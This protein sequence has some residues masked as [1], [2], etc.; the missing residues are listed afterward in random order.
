MP[1]TQEPTSFYLRNR[2]G[3]CFYVSTLDEAL[4]LFVA[5]NGYRLTL[6]GKDTEI[7][8]RRDDFVASEMGQV[9]NATV[10][11]RIKEVEEEQAVLPSNV[12][13]FPTKGDK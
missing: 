12:I 2:D 9:S 8:I 6:S 11:L 13:P 10:N 3:D 7:V 1:R 5:D 4:S